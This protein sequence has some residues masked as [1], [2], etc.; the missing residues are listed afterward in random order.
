MIAM[1]QKLDQYQGHILQAI[2]ELNE[3]SDGGQE[4]TY[5]HIQNIKSK[6]KIN[7]LKDINDICDAVINLSFKIASDKK[8]ITKG[9]LVLLSAKYLDGKLN[10]YFD[11]LEDAGKLIMIA[12]IILNKNI[13]ENDEAISVC[14]VLNEIKELLY[15]KVFAGVAKKLEGFIIAD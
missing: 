5:K 9:D 14:A 15:R 1:K 2:K 3:A 4:L 11:E 6:C 12:N 8:E 13:S 7:I 10:K